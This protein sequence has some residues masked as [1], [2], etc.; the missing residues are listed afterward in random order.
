LTDAGR[1]R[2]AAEDPRRL[3][4]VVVGKPTAG[5]ALRRNLTVHGLSD[6]MMAPEYSLADTELGIEC[7]TF[8]CSAEAESLT[9]WTTSLPGRAVAADLGSGS[10]SR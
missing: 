3:A 5:W 1:R 9:G 4:K 10:L 8:V 7:L 6:P 2:G